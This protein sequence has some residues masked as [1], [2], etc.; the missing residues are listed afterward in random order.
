MSRS[1][2]SAA[3]DTSAGDDKDDSDD[4]DDDEDETPSEEAILTLMEFMAMSRPLAIDYLMQYEGS[5][6][7]VIAQ[8]L[9]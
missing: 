8:L 2:S 1:G 3:G 9:G 5:A 6:E 4:D 7:A